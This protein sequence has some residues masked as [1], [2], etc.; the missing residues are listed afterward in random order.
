MN[1]ETMGR[2]A[3]LE[4]R[5]M[6]LADEGW[7]FKWDRASVRFGQCNYRTKTISMSA[8]LTEANDEARCRNT[9][10][11]EIAH[12]LV[13]HSHGHDAVWAAKHRELGGDGRARYSS[14]EVT[15]VQKKWLVSCDGC[16]MNTQ[17][18]RRRQGAVCARCS[19][20]GSYL[21]PL[22]WKEN[23]AA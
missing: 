6:G 15:A 7:K 12:A 2:I 1:L 22:K 4:L 17:V 20:S 9:L 18:A 5:A 13:G 3:R 11:H 8:R 23:P 19:R 14:L 21:Y 16:G 10:T